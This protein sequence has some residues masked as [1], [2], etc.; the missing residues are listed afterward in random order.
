MNK[1]VVIIG[2]IALAGIGIYFLTKKKKD[3]AVLAETQENQSQEDSTNNSKEPTQK[4][5]WNKILKKGS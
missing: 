2:L 1:K 3:E 5:D 4:S